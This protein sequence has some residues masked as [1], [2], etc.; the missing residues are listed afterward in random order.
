[1]KKFL[2]LINGELIDCPQHV[3]VISPLNLKPAGSVPALDK[4]MINKAFQAAR[5]TQKK[6]EQETL[7]QRIALMKKFISLLSKNVQ[8]MAET[9]TAEN[10]KALKDSVVEVQRTIE[11]IEYTIEEVRRLN[12]ETYTGDGFNLKNKIGIFKRVAK[13]VVLA[14]SPFNY[15]INLALSKIAPALLTGNTVVFKPATNGSL[16]GAFIGKLFYQSGFPAGVINVVTGRG[17]DIGDTLIGHHESNLISFTGSV[18]IGERIKKINQ[19]ADLVLELGGKDPMLVCK[20]ADLKKAAADIIA[21]GLSYSGQ[22]CTA[23]KLV[24]VAESV[25]DQL[26]TYLKPLVEKLTVGSGL[27]NNFIVPLVTKPAATYVQEL[28]TDALKQNATLICGNKVEDNLVYPTVIDHVTLKMRLATEEPFGPVIPIVRV[29]DEAEMLAV[30]N[31]SD[32][33]LQASVYTKDLNEAFRLADAIDAGTINFNSKSQRGPDSFP[34]LGV[35]KS[36]QG[37]QGIKDTLMSVTRPKG[38]VINY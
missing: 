37:V 34:F 18:D 10:G 38:I 22:R 5:T 36:G 35:K 19:N 32:F 25:A 16:T 8:E 9:I 17:R 30:A 11:Y 3:D 13:G 27:E 4:D 2:A 24:V 15:P 33:G 23:I 29:K 21:G 12:P 1:M 31:N 20:S 6:W 7:F 14:I 26:I 28:I